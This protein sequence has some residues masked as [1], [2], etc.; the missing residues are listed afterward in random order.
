M[1]DFTDHP[2]LVSFWDFR[3]EPRGPLVAQGR[4]A[5]ALYE[6]AGPMEHLDGEGPFGHSLR[7]REG[8]WLRCPR[9]DGPMLDLGGPDAEVT[10][11]AWLRRAAKSN[12]ICQAVAGMWDEMRR[13]R[14]YALFIGAM[15]QHN[16]QVGHVSNVGGPTQG[17]RYCQTGSVGQTELP[18]GRWVC[19]TM[20]F[21]RGEVASYLDG[22]P[23]GVWERN[24]E[25]FPFGLFEGGADGVDFTVGAVQRSRAPGPYD[26]FLVGD[27]GGLAVFDQ[28]LDDTEIVAI[29]TPR[30]TNA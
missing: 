18:L 5:Y 12:G 29:A 1:T 14:Q 16:R 11:V 9:A 24:P 3:G 23:D 25:A 22:K 10:L 2:A 26:N 4:G 20:A 17:D 19:L 30:S 15:N 13:C 7:F 8:Q 27:L 6:Q 28:R 21:G